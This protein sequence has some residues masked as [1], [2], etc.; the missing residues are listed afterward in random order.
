M[1]NLV[2][3]M[4]WVAVNTEIWWKIGLICL[5]INIVIRIVAFGLKRNGTEF[6]T[7]LTNIIV[8]IALVSAVGIAVCGAA[9]LLFVIQNK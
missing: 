1:S 2:N 9:I 8:G 5:I 6:D 4:K 3:H 7:G